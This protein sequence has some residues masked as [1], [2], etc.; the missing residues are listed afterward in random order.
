M[1][2]SS[3]ESIYDLRMLILAFILAAV[4]TTSTVNLAMSSS[5]G[6]GLLTHFNRSHIIYVDTDV[7]LNTARGEL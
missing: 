2:I 4:T 7:V 3:S 1:S 5:G 6:K